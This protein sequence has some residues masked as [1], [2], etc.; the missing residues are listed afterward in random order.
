MFGRTSKP[1]TRRLPV[2][3]TTGLVGILSGCSDYSYHEFEEVDTFF[4][5]AAEQNDILMVV[6][7][8]ASMEPYQQELG[9]NFNEFLS[10]F[11]TANVN[12]RLAVITTDAVSDE[13]GYIRG[14]VLTPETQDASTVFADIV[15]VGVE[16]NG[17]EM[18]FESV[19]K[20]V[21]DPDG[22]AFNGEFLRA[23]AYLSVI[24]V[25]DEFDSSPDP[26]QEYVAEL[27]ASK[28]SARDKIRVGAL[29]A[30]DE[31]D[32]FGF[33]SST[34]YEY[35]AAADMTGG[36]YYDI[37]DE[38]LSASLTELSQNISRMYDAFYL[39]E[40]PDTG[41][42]EVYIN[43]E[44]VPCET[45]DWTYETRAVEGEERGTIVFDEDALPALGSKLTVRYNRGSGDLAPFC[46][47]EG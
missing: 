35:M 7:N 1:P 9:E 11:I 29:V 22:V 10:W 6:D 24:F 44:E 2:L 37:C 17:T 16:G 31:D 20:A 30:I 43:D 8:S 32:C 15:N 18:G 27:Q 5:S 33:G 14:D 39:T 46:G 12:Y 38:D 26:I 28:D 45:G 19:R 40:V 41:S 3:V 23:D 13:A 36:K 42:L 25:T 47:A 21:I 34:G 4:Q